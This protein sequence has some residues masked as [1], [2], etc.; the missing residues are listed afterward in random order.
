MCSFCVT[1]LLK[2]ERQSF[3]ATRSKLFQIEDSK[4]AERGIGKVS[5]NVLKDDESKSRII[6]RNEQIGTIRMNV[7]VFAEMK[8]EMAGD[9]GVKFMAVDEGKPTAFL[10]RFAKPTEASSLFDELNARI[11]KLGKSKVAT[12]SPNQEKEKEKKSA[13]VVESSAKGTKQKREGSDVSS[14]IDLDAV[15]AKK[16]KSTVTEEPAAAKNDVEVA[17]CVLES[18]QGV[19]GVLT[20][21]RQESG[22]CLAE[23]TFDGLKPGTSYKLQTGNGKDLGSFKGAQSEK[24]KFVK[25]MESKT[26]TSA[27]F[28]G[29]T[30]VLKDDGN[31]ICSG[32][33]TKDS[34][35]ID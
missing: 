3:P 25:K 17:V 28:V 12:P 27:S 20:F 8:P 19:S 23:A 21:V 33:V 11:A 4:W 9:K 32:S 26:Q 13:A 6:F 2:G 7:A 1:F 22:G 35:L 24:S 29:E 15:S 31:T 14:A 16:A 18:S 5:I 34:V 10:V 30:I